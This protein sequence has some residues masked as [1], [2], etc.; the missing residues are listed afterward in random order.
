[1][2]HVDVEQGTPEWLEARR[3]MPTASQFH[4]ILTPGRLKIGE[5]S[6]KYL[7]ELVAERLLNVDIGPDA[8]LFMT[9]GSQMEEEA[10]RY[11]EFQTGLETQKAGL[12]VTD[13]GTVGC[14]PDRLIGDRGGLEIKTPSAA[15]HV[16]HLLEGVGNKYRMQVQGALWVTGRDWWDVLSYN[17]ELPP[18]LIRCFPAEDVQ[19]AL[20]AALKDFVMQLE[21]AT[22]RL[23]GTVPV[24]V[25]A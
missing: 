1:M 14:S 16:E 7:C 24:A 4:R 3:G 22:Q 21:D 12:C 10:I 2:K 13:D 18:A 23:R 15:V 19:E 8:S 5:G 6:F 17:P 11:Y 9:R 25:G 20:S